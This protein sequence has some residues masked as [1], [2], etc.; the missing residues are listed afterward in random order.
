M[1]DQGQE[2]PAENQA[3]RQRDDHYRNVIALAGAIGAAV[4]DNRYYQHQEGCAQG[5]ARLDHTHS[6]PSKLRLARGYGSD[7]GRFMLKR[8]RPTVR[9]YFVPVHLPG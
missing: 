6:A 3:R 7:W 9:S 8:R 2:M 4:K 5:S 1:S